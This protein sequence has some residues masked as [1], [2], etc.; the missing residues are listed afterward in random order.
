MNLFSIELSPNEVAVLRQSLDVITIP[1]K[2]A[3]FIATL[4]QKLEHELNEIGRTLKAQE[5][6][7][8]VELDAFIKAE[9][10]KEAKLK[11]VQ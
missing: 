11:A 6:Q 1:G 3:M 10:R 2:D 9:A 8:Q 5:Q 7:K 4:Q